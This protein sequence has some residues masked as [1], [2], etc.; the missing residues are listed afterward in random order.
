MSRWHTFDFPDL[1]E[2]AFRPVGEGRFARGMTLE[3][4]G[5]KAP[6]PDPRMGEAAIRMLDLNEEQFRDYQKNERPWMQGIAKEVLG[7]GR[8]SGRLARD[9]FGFSREVAN[10]QLSQADRQ[11]AM[12]Q[13]QTER[14]NALSDYQL[15]NMR[16]NDDRYRNTAIPFEDQMLQDVRR[17]D[18]QAYRDEQV[19]AAKADVGSAFDRMGLQ[20]SRGAGRMG[21]DRAIRAT[22]DVGMER[23]KA[24][25]SAAYKTEQAARQVGLSS[26]MQMYG[27][28][29]GLAG[30]GATSAQLAAG[31]MGQG[32]GA[33]GVG[34]G[35]L[36]AGIGAMGIGNQALGAM[37]AGGSA[38]MSAGTGYLGA[39]N[40]ALSGYNSGM[41]S[42]IS[43]LGQYS[44]LGIQAANANA[45]N[46]PINTMLGAAA[47]V[48]T[49]WAM[50][51]FL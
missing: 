46:S 15:E 19:N 17:F 36:N 21:I 7:Q 33:I 40:A 20:A 43:G 31:A 23:A 44:S 4:G 6:P 38:M 22:N 2:G 49:S 51:K 14:A 37:N 9:Q 32:T 5:K 41:G 34:M 11:M 13:S 8:E 29:R 28:M 45:Q 1:P 39:N 42:G 30:L 50:G 18:T 12:A 35:G 26:K 16:F 47:G 24:E 10:R 3:G 27:G 48:G 25:A